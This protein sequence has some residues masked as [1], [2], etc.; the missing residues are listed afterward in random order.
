MALIGKGVVAIWNGINDAAEAEFIRWHVREHI[1]ERVGLP[2]FLRGRRYV[3]HDALPKYFNF[4]EADSVETLSSPA[5]RERLNDPTPW[6]RRVVREFRDTTRAICD[7]IVSTGR[8]EG[9][10][11]KTI[12]FALPVE[13]DGFRSQ[14]LGFTVPTLHQQDG[15]VGVHLLKGAA[16]DAKSTKTAESTLRSQPDQSVAWVLLVE[17]VEPDALVAAWAIL[18]SDG[19]VQ[20]AA[21]PASVQRGIYRLQF[22]LTKMELAS[23]TDT[24]T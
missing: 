3:S 5:Y 13:Q 23:S 24:K 10:W 6:T 22:S 21:D 4:Y 17:G 16:P 9:A 15:I 11:I 8:G 2:G 20:V 7:V 1:P 14:M 18:P 12:R 19:D